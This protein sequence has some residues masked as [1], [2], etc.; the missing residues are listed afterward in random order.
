MHAGPIERIREEIRTSGPLT[1]ARFMELALYGEGG[2]YAAP[3]VGPQGDF[4]TSPH[5]HPVFAVML[6]R[7]IR[8]IHASLEEPAPFRIVEAGAGDGTLAR[9]LLEVLTDLPL[10]YATV[11]VSPGA[12]EALGEVPGIAAVGGM[13][14]A[15]FDLLIA[16]ELLDNLPFRLVRDGVEIG[17]GLDA[18]GDL[19][20]EA[21]GVT[22]VVALARAEEEIVPIGAL[23][24]VDRIAAALLDRPGCALL[25]DYG[26][27][28]GTGGPLH[29]YSAQT[30]I[31]DVLAAPGQ[32]DITAGVDFGWIGA[33]AEQA[34]VTAF[35]T[36]GQREALLALGFA[37]WFEEQLA[38][39]QAQLAE[40]DA[41][42]AVRTWSAKSRASLLADPAGLGRFRWLL[43]A[44]PGL[45]APPWH[46][47]A[48][49]E[50]Q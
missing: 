42:G 49:A 3:P 21:L 17:I 48:A 40:R 25:I 12:R 16:N 14:E 39:Q 24:F 47:E 46:R 30:I 13:V 45:T 2:Y 50:P 38:A 37:S 6:G 7:A 36:V 18:G 4:V 22:D 43:L 9:G 41:M 10:A 20:E 27:D 32:T 19:V 1:F 11:D 44:S 29:G 26:S 5:V 34:G 35:P 23:A 31:E 28:E 8:Q 33:R 15:P